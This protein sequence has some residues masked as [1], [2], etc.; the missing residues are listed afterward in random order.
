MLHFST[1]RSKKRRREM[2]KVACVDFFEPLCNLFEEKISL[3][4]EEMEL[5]NFS[6]VPSLCEICLRTIRKIT[7]EGEL[8]GFLGT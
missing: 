5:S 2:A 7:I 8:E 1:K 4:V 6:T 3:N